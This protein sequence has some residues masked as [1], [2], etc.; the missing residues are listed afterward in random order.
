MRWNSSIDPTPLPHWLPALPAGLSAPAAGLSSLPTGLAAFATGLA[1]LLGG[2]A[3]LATGLAALAAG[4]PLGA[5]GASGVGTR[6]RA[7]INSSSILCCSSLVSTLS[8]RG[9]GMSFTAG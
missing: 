2:L 3:A 1:A 7:A 5:F 8:S 4:L 6:V 9:E